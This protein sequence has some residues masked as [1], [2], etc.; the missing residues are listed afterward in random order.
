MKFS[1]IKVQPKN[2]TL[3]IDSCDSY[4]SAPIGAAEDTLQIYLTQR[5]AECCK[6]CK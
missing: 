3:G 4:R 6:Q 5:T 2:M 1:G